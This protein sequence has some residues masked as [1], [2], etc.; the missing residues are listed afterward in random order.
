M[1]DEELTGRVEMLER[2]VHAGFERID[3]RFERLHDGIN[4]RFQGVDARLDC[5]DA[6]FERFEALIRTENAETRRPFGLLTANLM[7]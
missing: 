3:A 1:R 4:K 6:R 2:E 7:K 5:V